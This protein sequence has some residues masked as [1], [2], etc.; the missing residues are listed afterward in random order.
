M[1]ANGLAGRFFRVRSS[2]TTASSSPRQARWNPPMPLIATTCP[3]RSASQAAPIGSSASAGLDSSGKRRVA[4]HDSRGPQ[5][6][7]AM[8]WAWKRRSAGLRYSAAH[9]SHIGKPAMVVAGRS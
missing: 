8:V 6:A 4:D 1:T 9:S 3:A 2:M 7:Q 5:S